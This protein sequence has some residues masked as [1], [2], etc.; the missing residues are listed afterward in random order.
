MEPGFFHLR[1]YITQAECC[2][3]TET[4]IPTQEIPHRPDIQTQLYRCAMCIE[5]I[6]KTNLTSYGQSEII[7][8]EYI[9]VIKPANLP[10]GSY[11]PVQTGRNV[12]Y[13]MINN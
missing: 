7:I 11:I 12:P 9:P 6:L 13:P 2:S 1:N 8:I 3:V 10:A 4:T 5:I